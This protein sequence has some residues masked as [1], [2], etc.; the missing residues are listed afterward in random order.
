V[1]CPPSAMA[2]ASELN[3]A[4]IVVVASCEALVD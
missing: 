1:A 2:I 4:R 3:D